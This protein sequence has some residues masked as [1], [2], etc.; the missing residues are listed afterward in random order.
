MRAIVV[1]A[2]LVVG[3][4][5]S[6]AGPPSA[7]VAAAAGMGEFPRGYDA[8]SYTLD[9]SV[10]DPGGVFEGALVL[11]VVARRAGLAEIDLDAFSR[12][13]ILGV[14]EKDA[15]RTFRFE[16]GRLRVPLEPPAADGETRT[17]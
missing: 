6:T 5:A 4:R 8:V 11:E 3:C 1:A 12:M 2:T 7:A 17:L 16:D 13:E 14:T 10:L 9:L 15:P